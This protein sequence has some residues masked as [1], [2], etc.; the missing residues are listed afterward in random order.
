MPLPD[1]D[2]TPLTLLC[3]IIHMRNDAVPSSQ[4]Q[5]DILAFTKLCDK[6]ACISAG[7]PTLGTWVTAALPTAGHQARS[8]MLEASTLLGYSI[9]SQ[10]VVSAMVMYSTDKDKAPRDVRAVIDRVKLPATQFLGYE[11]VT[12]L[13]ADSAPC[14]SHCTVVAKRVLVQQFG[15]V[16][17]W[18]LESETSIETICPMLE[19]IRLRDAIDV[20]GRSAD[21]LCPVDQYDVNS[22]EEGL[23]TKATQIREQVAKRVYI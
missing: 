2:P 5:A 14:R 21:V 4:P 23:Q 12:E 10:R 18:P 3:Y 11:V 20:G 22:R 7:K 9:L 1:D 19:R 6:H 16:G 13:N 15:V 8:S 17:L